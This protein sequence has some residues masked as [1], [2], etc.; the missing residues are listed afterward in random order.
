MHIG[1]TIRSTDRHP[2]E[3]KDLPIHYREV[4]ATFYHNLGIDV[5]RITFTDF[6]GRPHD[7]LDATQPTTELVRFQTTE[8]LLGQHPRRTTLLHVTPC[9]RA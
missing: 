5:G 8:R 4:L 3:V 6:N 2:E 9:S 7:L 1:Q